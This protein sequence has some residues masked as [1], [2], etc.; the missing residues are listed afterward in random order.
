MRPIEGSRVETEKEAVV[1]LDHRGVAGA[2]KR[3]GIGCVN[4]IG[5]AK[6]PIVMWSQKEKRQLEK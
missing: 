4:G 2:E 1:E 5:M 3:I 6:Q